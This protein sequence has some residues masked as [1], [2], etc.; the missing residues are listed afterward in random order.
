MFEFLVDSTNHALRLMNVDAILSNKLFFMLLGNR[1]EQS[2]GGKNTIFQKLSDWSHF[3]RWSNLSPSTTHG[4][5]PNQSLVG[6][7]HREDWAVAPVIV[8]GDGMHLAVVQISTCAI[9]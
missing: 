9:L 5:W 4:P 1:E 6:G 8:V 2:F 7:D 3:Q